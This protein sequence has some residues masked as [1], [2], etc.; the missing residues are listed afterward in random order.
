ADPA[1]A[2]RARQV[3]RERIVA[4]GIEKNDVGLGFTLHLLEHKIQLDGLKI[5]IPLS[6]KLGIRGY[7]IVDTTDLQAMPGVK[8]DTNAGPFKRAH[9]I[10]C[11]EI[12]PPLVEIEPQDHREAEPREGFRHVARIIGGI[13]KRGYIVVVGVAYHERD[14]FLGP[15]GCRQKYE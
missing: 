7:K 1:R 9:E 14:S 4:T 13:G 5:E 8:E 6:I 11:L 3:A 10:P 15:S 2:H 12:K